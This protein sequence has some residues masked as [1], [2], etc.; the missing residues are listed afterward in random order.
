MQVRKNTFLKLI[1]CNRRYI[2]AQ[3]RCVTHLCV[4]LFIQHEVL[5]YDILTHQIIYN[6]KFRD[7]IPAYDSLS[8]KKVG[9]TFSATHLIYSAM[10]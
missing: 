8:N 10:L 3:H 9:H 4:L 2:S 5:P 1:R 7:V 6:L